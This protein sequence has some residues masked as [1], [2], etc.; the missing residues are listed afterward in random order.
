MR[1]MKSY[2]G[3]V[4]SYKSGLVSI[5][6][7]LQSQRF[8]TDARNKSSSQDGMARLVGSTG[9]CHWE[10][11]SMKPVFIL[12]ILVL[13]TAC[14]D[15]SMQTSFELPPVPVQTAEIET[16]DVPL[17]FESLGVIKS[18]RT[19]E[20]RPQVSGMIKEVHFKDGQW[21]EEAALLYTIDDAPYAIRVQEQQSQLSQDLAHLNNAKKKHERFK[22]LVK[23]DLIAKVEWDELETKVA[24]HEAMVQADEARLAAAKLDLE[25][26]KVVAPIA[27]FAG[28][29]RFG[30]REHGL[31]S[32][33]CDID[34][35]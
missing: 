20:I 22:S 9:I 32:P 15:K 10:F 1:P 27:G 24:L 33:S 13:L 16:R 28:K 35:E 25:H 5:F 11:K 2:D 12:G 7:L 29:K 14:S 23:Q 34:A 30:Q 31:W 19:A 6:D 17:F 21:V 18:S 8:L 3:F 26:C 4:Q